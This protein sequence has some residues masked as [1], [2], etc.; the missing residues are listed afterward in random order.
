MLVLR[1]ERAGVTARIEYAAP[2]EAPIT[3]G[4][5]LGSLIVEVPG[6]PPAPVSSHF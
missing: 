5:E 3:A 1:E 6:Q 4:Q 2:I